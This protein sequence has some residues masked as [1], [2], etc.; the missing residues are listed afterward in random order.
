M[1]FLL[2]LLPYLIER[3][4]ELEQYPTVFKH[5]VKRDAKVFLKTIEKRVDLVHNDITREESDQGFNLMK[6][7]ADSLDSVYNDYEKQ[8]DHERRTK[9]GL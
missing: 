8:I 3:V 9:E 1:T 2:S 5:E 6:A 4:D 7:I